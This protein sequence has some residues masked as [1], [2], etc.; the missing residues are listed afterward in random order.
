MRDLALHALGFAPPALTDGDRLEHAAA[1][2]PA[3]WQ[4]L[5]TSED[6]TRALGPVFE[7]RVLFPGAFNP[8]HE[9]HR[10]IAKWVATRL[11]RPVTF[12]ICITNV[13]KPP[14][15]CLDLEARLAR[16]RPEE[17]VWLTRLPTFVEK[18][19]AFGGATFV[20]GT[21]TIVRIADPRYYGGRTSARDAAIARIAATSS[22]F[23]VFGRL[24]DDRFVTLPDL[25]LPAALVAICEGV[26]EAEFRQ[27]VSSTALRHLGSDPI[28]RN[29]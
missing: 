24:V 23:L 6:A 5:W 7:P 9:G 20:V 19:G 4:A 11:R 25:D 29:N 12:E 26:S 27:D 1:D 22:R 21:D 13:D 10:A 18:A 28:W 15:D 14:L 17:S 2:A 8:L 16:F 3:A